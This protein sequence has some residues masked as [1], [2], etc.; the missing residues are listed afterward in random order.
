MSFRLP[1]RLKKT[2]VSFSNHYG[3]VLRACIENESMSGWFV[4][5]NDVTY[6]TIRILST[7]CCG[8]L[9]DIFGEESKVLLYIAEVVRSSIRK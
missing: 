4:G 5:K 8:L 2:T 7:F 6:S 1:S 9:R 3:R